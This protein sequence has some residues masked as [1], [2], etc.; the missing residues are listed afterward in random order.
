MGLRARPPGQLGHPRVR[1]DAGH[2]GAG[3]LE[4]PGGYAGAAPY[5]EHVTPGA[6]GDDPVH[7]AGGVAGTGAVVAAGVGAEA[8]GDLPVGVRRPAIGHRRVVLM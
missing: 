3:R 6:G 4:E 2:H 1:V 7:Q 5:V 8:L